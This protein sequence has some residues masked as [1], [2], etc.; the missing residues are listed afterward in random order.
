VVFREMKD[1]VKHE[2]LPSKEEQEKIYFETKDDESNSTEE[3]ESKE[4]DP[5]TL[6][7][8]ILVQEKKATKKVYSI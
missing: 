6:V 5:H 2:F 4:E 7:L 8:R 1:V 3:Q